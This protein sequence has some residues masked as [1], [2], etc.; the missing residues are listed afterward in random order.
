MN[1]DGVSAAGHL[2]LFCLVWNR[3]YSVHG[4]SAPK[5]P[6]S[7]VISPQHSNIYFI[8]STTPVCVNVFQCMKKNLTSKESY[9]PALVMLN[10]LWLFK[11]DVCDWCCLMQIQARQSIFFTLTNICQTSGHNTFSSCSDTYGVTGQ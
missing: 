8:V 3:K 9:Q 2:A 6:Y 11:I 1:P 7:I 10:K 4:P 5:D